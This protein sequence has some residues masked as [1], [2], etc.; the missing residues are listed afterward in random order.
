M[1]TRPKPEQCKKRPKTCKCDPN[2]WEGWWKVCA[3]YTR[4]NA[5]NDGR[6]AICE[7]EE[8]CHT[9]TTTHKRTSGFLDLALALYLAAIAVTPLAIA[10]ALDIADTLPDCEYEASLY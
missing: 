9:N 4:S 3:N 5:F 8:A 1:N 10:L 6:C 7:H 2:L